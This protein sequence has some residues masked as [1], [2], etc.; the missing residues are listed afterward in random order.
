M[1]GVSPTAGHL[2]NLLLFLLGTWM[3]FRLVLPL[4]RG[5]AWVAGA[6]AALY[7]VHPAT[8]EAVAYVASRG[9]LIALLGMFLSLWVFERDGG[10]RTVLGLASAAV[11]A[12]AAPWAVALPVI[13]VLRDAALRSVGAGPRPSSTTIRFAGGVLVA[14]GFL[15][16]RAGVLPDAPLQGSVQGPLATLSAV[17]WYARAL[18]LPTGFPADTQLM[19]PLGA[20]DPSVVWGAGILLT[21]LAI[22]AWALVRRR[23]LL[24]LATLGPVAFLIAAHAIL[25][26]PPGAVSDLFLVPGL[27]CVAAGVVAALG[28]A[29]ASARGAV[30][31]AIAAVLVL[32]GGITRDRVAAWHDEISLWEAVLR[33]RPT[34]AGAYNGIG[35]AFQREGRMEAAEAAYRSYVSYNPVDGRAMKSIG[36]IYGDMASGLRQRYIPTGQGENIVAEQRR[37]LRRVQ[38]QW[39]RDA[40][41]VWARAGLADGGGTPAL[42]RE[43]HE[44]RIIGAVDM[45]DLVEAKRANDSLLALDGL[46]PTDVEG[47]L[48]EGRTPRVRVR[49][50]LAWQVFA[51]PTAVPGELREQ[52]RAQRAL[53]LRDAGIDPGAST[54]TGV[55]ALT[56]RYEALLRRED[57]VAQDFLRQIALYGELRS[58]DQARQVLADMRRRLPASPRLEAARSLI[59]DPDPMGR[60]TDALGNPLTDRPGLPSGRPR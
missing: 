48:S 10:A 19:A 60:R 43:I 57:V 38:L 14:L 25:R 36:D 37:R 23:F 40:L 21:V 49:L 5:D 3:V 8:A 27:F 26:L 51:A 29:P 53:I 22:A 17:S 13:L 28:L 1:F 30:V 6:G 7:A 20:A 47:V 39:Y 52:M 4:V 50:G 59:G 9:D 45:G 16:L 56:R 58:E 2:L 32:L 18:F 11:A 15:V 42:L 35:F 54:T 31:G 33:D 12:M 34:H 24:A 44:D 41:G 46:D 55:L